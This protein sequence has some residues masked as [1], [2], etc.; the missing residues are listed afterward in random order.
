MA[1]LAAR[2]GRRAPARGR[3]LTLKGQRAAGILLHPTSLPGRFG[4]GDLG[5]EADRFLEWAR[6]AGLGLW[7]VLPL[8]PTGPHGSPYG[9]SSAFAGNPLLISPERLREEGFL[10]ASEAREV[11]AFSPERVDFGEV[12]RWKE[13]LLRTSW[14]EARR[15]PRVLEELESFRNAPAQAAWLADWTLFAALKENQPAGWI[16][17]PEEIRR[18]LP[19]ALAAARREL[20]DEIGFQEYAQFLFFRQWARVKAEANRR[21]IAILG[22]MPIYVVHD[23]ADV[24]VRQDLFLLD[25][26]GGP[27]LVAGVPPDA[28]S[29]TGQLWGYPLYR[30]DEMERD[31]FSWWIA[32]LRQALLLAD[33]IRIDHFRGFAAGWSVP[34][35][36]ASA[37]EGQWIPAPGI[38]LFEAARRALGDITLVAEDLGVITD[39]VRQL[40]SALGIPGMKVLQFAFSEDDSEHLPHRHVPNAVVYT[41]THDND[42]TRGWFAA[43]P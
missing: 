25:A 3:L 10:S 30:W 17:W 11:P 20:E 36:A 7:Q 21:G 8:H 2:P 22:D 16:S 12:R 4:I 24:W 19:E 40:L 39:D 23:S 18:R 29:E 33:A 38:K 32:R 37:I 1:L 28:F 14:E 35:D 43:L 15:G 34:A 31:G 41:G 6:S 9:A 27:E 42:T 13:S 5:P 26:S